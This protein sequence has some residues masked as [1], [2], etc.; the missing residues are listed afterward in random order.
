M[1]IRDIWEVLLLSFFMRFNN[2]DINSISSK[3]MAPSRD[4]DITPH[5]LRICE[6]IELKSDES[7]RFKKFSIRLFFLVSVN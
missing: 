2:N 7:S 4:V 3:K 6:F 5:K 1:D